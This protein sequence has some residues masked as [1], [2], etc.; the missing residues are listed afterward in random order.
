MKLSRVVAI[1]ALAAGALGVI[2]GIGYLILAW[3][4]DLPSR[5]ARRLQALYDSRVP[6]PDARNAWFD[7]FGFAAPAGLDA[8]EQGLR[9]V[10]WIRRQRASSGVQGEDPGARYPNAA[11]QTAGLQQITDH[12]NNDTAAACLAAVERGAPGPLLENED[13]YLR[14]Y[15]TLLEREDWYEALVWR[16]TEPMPHFGHV[17][18]TQRVLLIRLRQA[19][20]RG[21]FASIRDTLEHDFAF[22][23]RLLERSDSLISKL[24]AVA[25][26]RQNFLYGSQVLRMLPPERV[27]ETVPRG[28]STPFTVAELSMWRCLAGEYQFMKHAVHAMYQDLYDSM[29]DNLLE[30][31]VRSLRRRTGSTLE[32]NKSAELFTALAEL[33]EVPVEQYPSARATLLMR[34]ESAQTADM[35]VYPLRVGTVEGMRR[36]ALLTAQL[37]SRAVPVDQV[38]AQVRQSDLRAP[39]DGQPF[40][41][42][43]EDRVLELEGPKGRRSGLALVY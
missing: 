1:C 26:I 9:R 37:R 35:A 27:L 3:R 21:E 18:T 12:C 19:A 8:H 41:W 4:G 23:R 29:D 36:L 17:A 15:R 31:L 14:R 39:F 5:D 11:P 13:A 24:M 42:R 7:T 2:A 25:L 43:E 16:E 10:E 32:I 38:K 30:R 34:V 20:S 28:W 22:A 33:F 40:A 6:A